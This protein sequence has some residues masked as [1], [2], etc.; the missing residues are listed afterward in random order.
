VL[1]TEEGESWT[2]TY[3]ATNRRIIHDGK[4]FDSGRLVIDKG[5][6]MG[7]HTLALSTGEVA[8]VFSAPR[9]VRSRNWQGSHRTWGAFAPLYA[10]RS[11]SDWGI[12]SLSEMETLQEFLRAKGGSFYGTLP[13]LPSDFNGADVDPSP[14]S[15]SSRVFWNEIHLDVESLEKEYGRSSEM[16]HR[17]KRLAELR[18]TE[19]VEHGQ[20][21]ALKKQALLPLAKVAFEGG[22]AE[23]DEYRAFL[24]RAPRVEAYAEFRA[25]G[26][27]EDK[28]FH[29]F[30]QFQMDRKLRKL[31]ERAKRGEIAGLYMDYP[32]GV[33]R[34]GFDAREFESS[35]IRTASAG[36]PPDPIFPGGQ[37]WGFAPLH[38]IQ[39]RETG[40]EYFIG[41]IRHHMRYASVLRLDHIM[42][43]HRIYA[44]PEGIDSK[45]GVYV[46]YRCDEFYAILSI[47]ASRNDVRV[48]GEDL[49]T[50]PDSVR[51]A[52][53]EHDLLRMWVLPFEAGRNPESKALR[54][55]EKALSC[56]NTHDMVPFEGY[57]QGVDVDLFE[58]LDVIDEEQAKEMRH[59]RE[60]TM[61][62]WAKNLALDEE[63]ELF[64]KLTEVMAASPCEL[65]LLN[66][67]DLWG[68]QD[69][70]NVPGTWKEHPNWRRKFQFTFERW[71]KDRELLRLL[72]RVT[73]LRSQPSPKP[74]SEEKVDEDGNA[75]RAESSGTAQHDSHGRRSPSLQ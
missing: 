27:D 67:E 48:V 24:M 59:E 29:L 65:C 9:K 61:M 30:V 35:F 68:E 51:N 75:K 50:V 36:A 31:N 22:L 42:A 52:L 56:L 34:S 20:V 60:V 28:R 44:I 55:P 66:L 33:S 6:P 11:E 3:R 25:K 46:R 12:G 43:L 15:P 37:N 49:G 19:L 10:L 32:V 5:L 1:T 21:Y 72:D 57:R 41:C 7:Y 14:Y 17:S 62:A 40:Y 74:K 16:A 58:K 45:C 73:E 47:E 69:P 39:L 70:Q 18:A 63:E 54:A 26:S 71:S 38:P 64:E 13:L 8:S 23:N 4:S 2:L 53:H